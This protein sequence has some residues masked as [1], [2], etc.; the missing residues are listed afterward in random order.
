MM[1]NLPSFI[2]P[3]LSQKY[4]KFHEGH[5]R[6]YLSLIVTFLPPTSWQC[7]VGSREETKKGGKKDNPA[8]PGPG[9]ALFNNAWHATGTM[10]ALPHL[11]W[12]K[13][14]DVFENHPTQW[15]KDI[16]LENRLSSLGG[17]LILYTNS[18]TDHRRYVSGEEAGLAFGLMQSYKE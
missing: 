18:E 2:F 10:T 4:V 3:F 9:I 14:T 13:V 15:R 8:N 11:S 12:M 5:I 7:C 16:R 6:F 17:R 1:L